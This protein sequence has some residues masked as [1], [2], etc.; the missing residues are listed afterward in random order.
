MQLT[1]DDPPKLTDSSLLVVPRMFLAGDK[2][3]ASGQIERP[4]FI[5]DGYDG[6]YG[7]MAMTFLT[8]KIRTAVPYTLS[9]EFLAVTANISVAENTHYFHDGSLAN[10]VFSVR[11][12]LPSFEPNLVDLKAPHVVVCY[13]E[14]ECVEKVEFSIPR[15]NDICKDGFGAYDKTIFSSCS[16]VEYIQK[17]IKLSLANEMF[18][19]CAA[20]CIFDHNWPLL[21]NFEY[22]DLGEYPC[23]QLLLGE[24]CEIENYT[25]SEVAEEMF[26]KANDFCVDVPAPTPYPTLPTIGTICDAYDIENG[27]HTLLSIDV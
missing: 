10:D 22:N 21:I 13:V 6:S 20:K 25:Y 16:Q 24:G 5:E 15:M 8:S 11:G 4:A 26:Q 2:I 18:H 3:L 14:Q 7:R 17:T 12:S 23:W 19:D 27:D 9:F 1:S